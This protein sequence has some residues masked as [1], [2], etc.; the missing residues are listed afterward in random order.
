MVDKL[1]KDQAGSLGGK[2]KWSKISKKKR[3]EMMRKIAQ[4]RWSVA[5]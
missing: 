3:S 2:K 4:A 1:T 5:L